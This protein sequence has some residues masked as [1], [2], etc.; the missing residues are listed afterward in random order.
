MSS[1]SRKHLWS[2]DWRAESEAE[3]EERRRREA[4]RAAEDPDLHLL[5]GRELYGGADTAEHPLPDRLHP[6]A[7]THRLI[8]ERFAAVVTDADDDGARI[9]LRDVAVAARLPAPGLQPGQAVEVTLAAA[10]PLKRTV[11]FRL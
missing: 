11:A 3:A 8:G 9:Q 10:D 2:G 1:M 4:E 5:D 6:D 7:D